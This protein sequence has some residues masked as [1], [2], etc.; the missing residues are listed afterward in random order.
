MTD[1]SEVL[2]VQRPR[3]R[4]PKWP[5]Y[6]HV[7]AVKS[8]GAGVSTVFPTPQTDSAE[9]ASLVTGDLA[10]KTVVKGNIVYRRTETGE[11]VASVIRNGRQSTGSVPVS[12][13]RQPSDPRVSTTSLGTADEAGLPAECPVNENNV[14]H[15]LDESITATQSMR[16]TLMSLKD[17]LRRMGGG[18]VMTPALKPIHLQHRVNIAYKLA[19]AFADYRR[20]IGAIRGGG[21]SC[22]SAVTSPPPVACSQAVI[23]TVVSQA[24]VPVT[25]SSAERSVA[26]IRTS[27]ARPKVTKST[28]DT[29][30]AVVRQ[31]S[32]IQTDVVSDDLVMLCE[33]D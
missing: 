15:I 10:S 7:D 16:R 14:E 18:P 5:K 22:T 24:S 28:A 1:Y 30:T 32:T 9:L 6:M 19:R 3:G 27:S 2:P 12:R 20:S 17:D 33:Q 23:P 11:V 4:P 26:V 13:G 31:T 25:C 21:R 8:A 29:R